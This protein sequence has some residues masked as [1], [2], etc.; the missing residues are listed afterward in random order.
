MPVFKSVH[1]KHSSVT[2]KQRAMFS[3]CVV[4]GLIQ[5]LFYVIFY[6]D[7]CEVLFSIFTSNFT[8]NQAPSQVPL[9]LSCFG[10]AIPFCIGK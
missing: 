10:C 8:S 1:R 7:Q 4:F 3:H 6:S 9:F 5:R 2:F